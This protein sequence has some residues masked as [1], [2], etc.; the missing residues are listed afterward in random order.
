MMT[1]DEP[2]CARKG[3]GWVSFIIKPTRRVRRM[4]KVKR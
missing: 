4:R 1:D 2:D 3:K